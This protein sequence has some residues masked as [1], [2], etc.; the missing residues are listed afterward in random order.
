MERLGLVFDELP[1]LPSNVLDVDELTVVGMDHYCSILLEE[2]RAG[3]IG[4]EPP[5]PHRKLFISRRKAA[6]RHL[7]NEDECWKILESRGYERVCM[8]EYDFDQQVALMRE[9]A[10]VFT[11]QGSGM[12]NVLFAP[13]GLHVIEVTDV[14]FATPQYYALSAA[15]GHHHWLLAGRPHGAIRPAYHDLVVD[16]GEVRSIVERVDDA[17]GR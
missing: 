17:L 9:T 13:R 14:T 11:L 7:A 2:L 15:L 10:A 16:A 8:E 3:F 12:A 4:V 6:W 1:V 5:P